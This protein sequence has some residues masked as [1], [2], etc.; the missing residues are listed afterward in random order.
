MPKLAALAIDNADLAERFLIVGV[1]QKGPPS[2]EDVRRKALA[3]F[4]ADDGPE[5]ARL[6]PVNVLDADSGGLFHAFAPQLGGMVLLDPKGTVVAVGASA[7]ETV[8]SEIQAI[9]RQLSGLADRLEHAE[10]GREAAGAVAELLDM[11]LKPAD[12]AARRFA[13]R[14]PISLAAP[15]LAVMGGRGRHDVV[16]ATMQDGDPKRRRAA[17]EAMAAAPDAAWTGPVLAFTAQKK[18]PADEVCLALRAACA[19]T[20]TPPAVEARVTELSRR[21]DPPV[22][23]CAIELLGRL[24]TPGAR[25]QLLDVLAKDEWRGAR[26]AAAV[27]LGKLGGDDAV[28]AL[29]RAAAEDKIDTVRAAAKQALAAL[30]KKGA[31]K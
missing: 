28:K 5:K 6:L 2:L 18:V 3:R 23:S 9:R 10:V 25:Q 15:V 11:G 26:I 24:G 17:F 4:A 7:L 12:D 31:P 27:A 8:R 30:A 29:E 16:L 13:A 22:R 21:A 14:C 19:L 1:H 20:P